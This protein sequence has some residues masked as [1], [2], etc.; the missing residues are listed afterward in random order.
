MKTIDQMT[1][2]ERQE[3]VF[4]LAGLSDEYKLRK[5]GFTLDVLYDIGADCGSVTMFAHSIFPDTRIVAVEPNPWSFSRLAKNAADIPQIVPINAA[6]GQGPLFQPAGEVGPLH[7]LVV[8]R[9]SPTWDNKLVPAAVQAI[10]LD[11]LYSQHG[12]ERYAVKVDIEGGEVAMIRHEP[13]RNVLINSSYFAAELHYWGS[14]REGMMEGV[15]TINRF[16]FELAQTHTI[17]SYNYGACG[18]VWAKRRTPAESV[19]AWL[20]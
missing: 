6:I 19:E 20:G 5:I 3:Q 7:W 4:L 2:D 17:Y 8:D 15:D 13:S 18:H 9:D 12:G 14:T 11:E 10:G 16:L 1:D